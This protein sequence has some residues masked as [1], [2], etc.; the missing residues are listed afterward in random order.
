M[1]LVPTYDHAK[2]S[3]RKPKDLLAINFQLLKYSIRVLEATF[4]NW[5]HSMPQTSL[6]F[7]SSILKPLDV[8]QLFLLPATSGSFCPPL[9]VHTHRATTTSKITHSERERSSRCSISILAF[10]SAL[11]HHSEAP[12]RTPRVCWLYPSQQLATHHHHAQ[13]SSQGTEE[14]SCEGTTVEGSPLM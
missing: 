9:P 4:P 14:D 2:W 1:L 12:F 6:F 5:F 8:L 3:E 11:S 13:F 7:P 10:V